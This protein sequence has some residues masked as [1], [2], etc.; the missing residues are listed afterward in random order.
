MNED[1]NKLLQEIS[2]P[3]SRD[4][5]EALFNSLT[6][7][8][9]EGKKITA[10]LLA[11]R[12]T[13]VDVNIQ[14]REFTDSFAASLQEIT[15]SNIALG[16]ARKAQ[17]GILSI[18]QK[19]Q[20]STSGTAKLSLKELA[21]LKT[22]AAIEKSR[23][24]N[25]ARA[26][27]NELNLNDSQKENLTT[28][29]DYLQAYGEIS[30][31]Q[32]SIL[33][34]FDEGFP[35]IDS[36]IQSIELAEESQAQLNRMTGLTGAALSN[37]NRIGV[38]ALGG[39]GINLGALE[40]D[41]KAAEEAAI[42]AADDIRKAADAAGD[43]VDEQAAKL[44]SLKAALPG[45]G[46][47]LGTALIDPLTIGLFSTQKLIQAFTTLNEA[48]TDFRRVTGTTASTFSQ[49]TSNAANAVEVIE[50]GVELTK[51]IG[52][53]AE[54][55]FGPETLLQITEAKNLL[56]LSAEQA[57]RIAI[58]NRVS[59]ENMSLFK[60]GIEAGAKSSNKL[61]K[62][63]ISTGL[64]LQD[65]LSASD[66]IALSLG[67]SGERL[68]EAAT[69]A[70]ALGL[71]L[72]AVNEIANSLLNFES[73]IENELQAQLLTGKQ[74]NLT[75]ARELALNNDLAGLSGEIKDNI[76]T[77]TEFAGMNR[78]A[79]EGLAS[80]IGVSRDQ[81]A[82]MVIQQDINNSLTAEQRANMMGLTLDQYQA[83]TAAESLRRS[84]QGIA[85]SV[86]G[87]VEPFTDFVTKNEDLLKYTLYLAGALKTISVTYKGMQK[88]QGAIIALGF[89]GNKQ[90]NQELLL[91][92]R[93]LRAKASETAQ[94]AAQTVF[95]AVQG[96]KVPLV[97][98][99]VGLAALAAGAL[100]YKQFNKAEDGLIDPKGGLV[101]SEPAGT[102]GVQ[103]NPKDQILAGTDLSRPSQSTSSVTDSKPMLDVLTELLNTVK[104]GTSVNIDGNK[105]TSAIVMAGGTKS[106]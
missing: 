30:A 45:I 15:K 29:V 26:I 58:A 48:Q 92:R 86:V 94:E 32:A 13:F 74:L 82:R 75:R 2:D 83:Q 88:I 76:V 8:S 51:Q 21:A 28:A 25:S 77:G 16:Q 35:N 52:M 62:S 38:R 50:V 40:E 1:L 104:K 37:L 59:G 34:Q 12:R 87:I 42:N 71:E 69:A 56:G 4:A 39:L 68:G 61:F 27:M 95:A 10:A 106:S 22:K 102:F 93:L 54:E 66:G 47:A 49:I 98:L 84:F 99:G 7:G 43:P 24:E 90:K 53:N 81:L 20:D 96:S 17:R 100:A 31:E 14:A 60:K 79:Q 67:M 9:Q 70:R 5:A 36:F 72:S 18:S 97:G 65:A 55:V 91:Q 33:R 6:K 63:G 73:S 44:A 89:I 3:S 11:V 23:L 46:K 78:I 19:I 105:L 64:A 101:V 85:Q 41:L 80:A 103:L 57:G